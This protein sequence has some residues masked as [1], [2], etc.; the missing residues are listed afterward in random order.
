MCLRQQQEPATFFL[1]QKASKK[2]EKV[3]TVLLQE[4]LTVFPGSLFWKQV[5]GLGIPFVSMTAVMQGSR[6]Y[7][8]KQ[9]EENFS[10]NFF[11]ALRLQAIKDRQQGRIRA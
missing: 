5:K 7:A 3:L 4:K 11:T 2:N 6:S 8:I 1:C 10:K 9:G